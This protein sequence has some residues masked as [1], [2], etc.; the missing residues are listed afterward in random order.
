MTVPFSVGGYLGAFCPKAEIV[1]IKKSIFFI[2]VRL[3]SL[4]KIGN[5][6]RICLVGGSAFFVFGT[7][8]GEIREI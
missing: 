1:V 4:T 6:N 3:V 8:I 5:L 2:L 7:R